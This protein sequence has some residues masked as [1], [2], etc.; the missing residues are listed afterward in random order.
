[1]QTRDQRHSG[2]FVGRLLGTLGR[3]VRRLFGASA[4][5]AHPPA[6]AARPPVPASCLTRDTDH[7]P[8]AAASPHKPMTSQRTRRAR[9]NDRER[10]PERAPLEKAEALFRSICEFLDADGIKYRIRDN[11]TAAEIGFS[12]E[13]A[14]LSAVIAVRVSPLVVGVFVRI[15]LMVPENRRVAMAETVSR[16]NFGLMIGAFDLDMSTGFMGFRAAMPVGDAPVTHDQFRA[17]IHAA[18]WTADRYHR[19]FCRLLFGDDLSPAEVIA[20]VEMA[21]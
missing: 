5:A 18:F 21:D 13:T 6:S 20:E 14:V 19:A 8:G 2:S 4:P 7:L 11:E 15:P 9:R 10:P 16:A 17:L 1:M 12:G 3:G